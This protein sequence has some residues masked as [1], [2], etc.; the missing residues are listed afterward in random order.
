V[1]ST[2]LS[3]K[4]QVLILLASSVGA[5]RQGDLME[6]LECPVKSHAAMRRDVLRPLH[7]ARLLEFDEHGGTLTL[8]PPGAAEADAIF[9]AH[10]GV[11]T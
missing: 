10:A 8:L 2:D 5:V 6:W 9:R 3:R 11:T 4:Q 1:L 7:R